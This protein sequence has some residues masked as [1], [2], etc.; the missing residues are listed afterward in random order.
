MATFFF[1]FPKY[2]AIVA[3]MEL[4]SSIPER[5]NAKRVSGIKL[6]RVAIASI[7]AVIE[8][9]NQGSR[10]LSLVKTKLQEARHWLGQELAE[11]R[12]P[13]PYPQSDNPQSPD[14]EPPTDMPA[15]AG[16]TQDPEAGEQEPFTEDIPVT[17]AEESEV[18]AKLHEA[19]EHADAPTAPQSL[20]DAEAGLGESP[21]AGSESQEDSPVS[22]PSPESEGDTVDSDPAE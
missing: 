15:P 10:E 9:M 3:A 18:A 13:T 1:T 16:S 2:Q 4:P 11:C 17:T 20:I 21:E 5:G 8:A 19:S 12:E 22:D 14:I 6:V 7:I